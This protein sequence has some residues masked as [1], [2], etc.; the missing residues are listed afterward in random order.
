MAKM[1]NQADKLDIEERASPSWNLPIAAADMSERLARVNWQQ[2]SETLNDLGYAILPA[3]LT[4]QEC[5]AVRDL[6]DEP[7]LFRSCVVMERYNF[8]QG[9]YKYFSHPLPP[10]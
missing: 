2:T 10:L 4:N 3:L 8:G 7:D 6:Y 9:E 1:D 5:M